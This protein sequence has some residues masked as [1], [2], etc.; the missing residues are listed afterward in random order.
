MTDSNGGA[1][2]RPLAVYAI[3]DRKDKNPYWLKLGAAFTNRDGSLT[4]L[5]DAV[6]T[7]TN[8]LQI[9]EQRVWEERAPNGH[10]VSSPPVELEVES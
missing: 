1:T 5:L 9:R 3:I 2:K 4:L 10:A 7:G 8:R 6:P